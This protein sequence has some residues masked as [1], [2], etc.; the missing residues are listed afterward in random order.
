[1]LISDSI[2]ALHALFP[3][4]SEQLCEVGILPSLLVKKPRLGKIKVVQTKSY[5]KGYKEFYL[6]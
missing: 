5:A 4:T 3:I 6:R 2:R 1:M